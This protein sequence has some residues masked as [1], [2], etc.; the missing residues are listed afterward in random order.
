VL[1]AGTAQQH[2]HRSWPQPWRRCRFRCGRE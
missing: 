1:G 2:I